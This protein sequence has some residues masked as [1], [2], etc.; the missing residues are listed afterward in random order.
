M[1][2]ILRDN[3]LGAAKAVFFFL[4][5]DVSSVLKRQPAKFVKISCFMAKTQRKLLFAPNSSLF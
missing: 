4:A 1:N 5:K 2:G 3:S